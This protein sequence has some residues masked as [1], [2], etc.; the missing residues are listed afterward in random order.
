MSMRVDQLSYHEIN[1]CHSIILHAHSGGAQP[2]YMRH[3]NPTSQTQ[4]Q[5]YQNRA[6]TVDTI[7][8]G[9]YI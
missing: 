2:H 9:V 1:H 4:S 7:H 5:K 8:R 3:Y 6:C